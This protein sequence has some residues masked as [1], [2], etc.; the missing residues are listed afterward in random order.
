[1][2]ALLANRGVEAE[3]SRRLLLEY[4]R[5]PDDNTRE[6]AVN[7]LAMLGTEDVIEGIWPRR[8]ACD[9]RTRRLWTRSKRHDD[10]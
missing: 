9:T 8:F 10:P 5:D 6:W 3:E 7:S 2:L 4:L 1:M